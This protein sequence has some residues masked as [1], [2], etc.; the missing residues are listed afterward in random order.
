MPMQNRPTKKRSRLF[1]LFLW[2]RYIGLVAALFVVMLSVTG[3]MLN[4]T[5]S[6]TLDHTAVKSP[7]I[8]SL[9]N[10]DI[11]EPKAFQVGNQH[12]SQVG[13][14]LFLNH[15]L[16]GESRSPLLGAV[17][18]EELIVAAFGQQIQLY[19]AQGELVEKLSIQRRLPSPLTSLGTTI[20]GKL[21][22][23]SKTQIWQTDTLFEKFS[24]VEADPTFKKAWPLQL[25]HAQIEKL[26]ALYTGHDISLE[27][28]TLDLHSGRLFGPI[29]VW[30]IDIAAILFILLA[31]SGVWLWSMRKLKAKLHRRHPRRHARH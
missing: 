24:L 8:L 21:L 31:F 9:Y 1:S 10:I 11:P 16:I 17:E 2:H 20:L 23:Q 7:W 27:R 12:F 14:Q 19:T 26:K 29:G 13:R 30:I 15:V 4:H 18:S 22:I 25:K 6:L 5:N 28:V 3:I